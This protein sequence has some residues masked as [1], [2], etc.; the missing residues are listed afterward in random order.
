MYPLIQQIARLINRIIPNGGTTGQVLAKIDNT[1]Y[2]THWI[3][4]TQGGILTEVD[5]VFTASDAFPITSVQ[6]SNW[7]TAYSWGNHALVGYLTIETDP[8]FVA[9]AA[10]SI[11]NL[12]ITNWNDAFSKEHVHSNLSLLNSLTS[13]GSGTSALFDDGTYKNIPIIIGG[14]DSYVQYNNNGNLGADSTFTFNNSSKLLSVQSLSTNT[15][16]LG[17]TG[18]TITVNGGNNLVFTDSI[19]GSKTLASLIGGATNYWTTTTGGIYYTNKVGINNA[20]TLTEALT[21]TGNIAANDFNSSYIRYKNNNILIGPNAGDNETGNYL[22]YIAEDNTASPLIYGDFLN[23]EIIFNADTYI[24]TVKRLAFG[25][26]LVTVRRDGSGNL[27]FRDLHA[28]GGSPVILSDLIT[29]SLSLY[30]LKSDFISYASVNS[31]SA[32][33]LTTWSKASHIITSGGGTNFLGDDGNYHAGG[34]GGVTPTDGIFKFDLGTVKYRPYTDKTE[35]GGVSSAG[36]FRSTDDP[37]ASNLLIW[38]GNLQSSNII[39]PITGSSSIGILYFGS[40]RFIHNY[41]TNN[42]FIGITSGNFTTT[43]SKNVCLGESTFKFNTTGGDSVAIGYQALTN[44]TTGES[45]VAIGRGAMASNVTGVGNT[46]IGAGSLLTTSTSNYNVAIGSESLGNGLIQDYN[47]AVGYATLLSNTSEKNTVIGYE[48]GIGNITGSNNVFIGY[49]AG[50]YETGSNTLFIDSQLRS[51]ESDARLK[52]LVYGIFDTSPNNQ[53]LTV[54]GLLK[55]TNKIDYIAGIS[56]TFVRVPGILKDFYT[57]VATS[58]TG[59]T[60]LYTYTIPANVLSNDGDKLVVHYAVDS[61]TSVT[62]TLLVSFGGSGTGSYSISATSN[63]IIIDIIFIRV[64]SSV[65]RYYRTG[66]NPSLTSTFT[67]ELTGLDFTTSNILKLVGTASSGTF[68]AKLG[69]IEYKPAG[70]N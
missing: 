8:I 45:N 65:L 50:Y 5:P 47:V 62:G 49:T 31:I 33:N 38:D 53:I 54:N 66:Y 24:N 41:G 68:T 40:D 13:L 67:S 44:N 39:L 30:S 51:N 7:D 15:I 63:D 1:D 46:S 57:D 17:S 29:G 36:K 23:Q 12:D 52:A 4:I 48:A 21:V 3:S 27:E 70:L 69:Y 60:D 32:A 16:T 35:A 22:L 2:N 59:A 55:S 58:G 18:V 10:H 11:V 9:S 34:G 43:G 56:S 14:A 26:S 20:S 19:S 61:G 6:I 28:N 42:L 64:S 25:D 37:T